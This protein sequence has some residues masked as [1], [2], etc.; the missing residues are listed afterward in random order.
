[1][2]KIQTSHCIGLRGSHHLTA[3]PT[4]PATQIHVSHLK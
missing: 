1:M 2:R 4:D 3:K